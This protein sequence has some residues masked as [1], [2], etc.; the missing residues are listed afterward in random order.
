MPLVPALRQS[1]ALPIVMPPSASTGKSLSTVVTADR[2]SRPNGA[3]YF[4]FEG[5]SKI[6][7]H[8]TKSAPPS[9]AATASST[10]CVDAPIS[11]SSPKVLRIAPASIECV[12]RCTPWAAAPAAMS[13]RSFTS[14]FV[15]V[16]VVSCAACSHNS[17]RTRA[18]RFFSRI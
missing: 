3:P 13:A 18:D 16:P 6:G 12:V 5:V 4:C 7:P 2:L 10:E 1:R 17:N 14:N 15:A 11:N 8:T 9:R